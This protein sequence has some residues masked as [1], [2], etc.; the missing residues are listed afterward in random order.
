MKTKIKVKLVFSALCIATGCTTKL[1][2][3]KTLTRINNIK[4]C[5]L[6]K[7][8]GYIHNIFRHNEYWVLW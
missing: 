7:N 2:A 3:N 1:M 5:W 6:L 4:N 8:S